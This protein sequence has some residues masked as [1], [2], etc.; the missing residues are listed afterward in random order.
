MA[1]IRLDALSMSTDNTSSNVNSA[2][3]PEITISEYIFERLYQ[4]GV[5]SVFGVPGDFNLSLLEHIYDVKSIK[6]IGTCNELNAAYAADA[7]AKTSRQMGAVLTTFGVGELSA[8]NGIAGAYSEFVPVVHIVG[9]SP[10]P[11]K[12]SNLV[13]NFHHLITNRKMYQKPDHYVY[14]KLAQTFSVASASIEDGDIA[15]TCDSVDNVLESVWRESRP[16]YIFLPCDLTEMK[17]PFSRLNDKPLKKSYDSGNEQLVDSVVSEILE[18]IYSKQ[19][20]SIL[21]DA[22]ISKFR[23]E[24]PF[25]KLVKLLNDKVNLFDTY[26]AKGIFSEDTDRFVGTY[27]GKV[28][29]KQVSEAIEASDLV[30]YVGSFANEMNCGFFSYKLDESKIIDLNPQYIRIGKKMYTGVTFMDVLPKLIEKL[31]ASRINSSVRYKSIEK[32]SLQKVQSNI[33]APLTEADLGRSLENLLQPDDILIVETCSFMT[34]AFQLNMNDARM[35]SQCYWGSIG[36]ALPATLGA[37]LALRDFQMPG[38]VIT[39]EGDGSAQMS[40]QELTSMIRYEVDA[41]MIMLNNSGYTIERAIKGPY[42]GYNDICGNWQW[43]KMLKVFGD[44]N[45]EKSRSL[46]ITSSK[47]LSNLVNAGLHDEGRF[48]LIELILPKFDIPWHYGK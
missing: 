11:E 36:Y 3:C 1:P 28:G 42:S 10:L 31:D 18:R 46:Q 7:Y 9:T 30:L 5:K 12:R 21:A 22:F 16:G 29:S 38:K 2:R 23:M 24:K 14:E 32:Q 26:M 47:Q 34:G 40:L 35:V 39:V 4:M 43:T 27:A 33:E 45:E 8:L 25:E 6:W 19:N 17:V 44:I 13:K 15:K 41:I 48:Q 20:V 37:C